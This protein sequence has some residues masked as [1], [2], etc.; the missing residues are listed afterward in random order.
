MPAFATRIQARKRR[1]LVDRQLAQDELARE[2]EAALARQAV[3]TEEQDEG[4]GSE[5]EVAKVSRVSDTVV[6]VFRCV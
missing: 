3:A 4:A 6:T 5:L 2:A 1:L